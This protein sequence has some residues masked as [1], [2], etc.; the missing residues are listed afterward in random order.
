MNIKR[1]A[2]IGAM[3]LLLLLAGL[4]L[5]RYGVPAPDNAPAAKESGAMNG[6]EGDRQ[7]LYWYDPM[8]PQHRFE[9]P[10]PSP[11]MDMDLV[12]RYAGGGGSEQP[13]VQ[14]EAAMVQSLGIRSAS[15][16]STRA[17]SR[18]EATGLV[19]F[20]DRALT[21]LQ[22]PSM[23]FVDKAWPLAEGDTVRR[24]QPLLR[25]RVP[26][27]TGAQH[28]WLALLDSGDSALIASG[29]E[30]LRSLG[31]PVALISSV[32]RQRQL[33]DTWTVTAPHDGV[34]RTLDAR[35]GMTLAAG[36]SMAGIQ[37]L[38]PVWIEIAMPERQVGQV[39]NGDVVEVTVQGALREGR[40]AEILPQVNQATRT[41]PVRVI[42]PN[43][44][45]ELRPGMSAQVRLQ[46]ES[47]QKALAV[48][49]E[50]LLHTGQRTLVMLDEGEG[51]YR[52]QAVQPGAE[53]GEQTL[54]LAGL[55]EGQKVVVSGQ[56]L[57]DSE[58]SLQ[59]IAIQEMAPP[60]ATDGPGALHHAEGVVEQLVD[61]KVRLRHG[62]FE[63][64]GM[65]AMT[66]RFRLANDQVA[67]GIAVGDRVRIGVR[68]TDDGL[69]V[70]SLDKQAVTP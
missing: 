2:L 47:E 12:P 1:N 34:I 6:E 8:Y 55:E 65:P 40:V 32:E 5:G 11:F 27:W 54:I 52:P 10:G 60:K 46:G 66:M 64:L 17:Q 43:G 42:L 63:T 44:N 51:R 14:V 20:N 29:R 68:D 28:E 36:A 69:I 53:L 18:L 21:R 35:A 50:A 25:L 15:V 3:G 13:A 16:T 31:M 22:S 9:E 19:A 24:G 23:A 41:V 57:L 26:A 67:G 56:F 59:G 62:P 70:V 45:G 38:D 49:T 33:Q 4:Y 61:G 7:V 30:R 48:P 37:S 39:R 58:A